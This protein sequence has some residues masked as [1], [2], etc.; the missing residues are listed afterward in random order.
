MVD[1]TGNA[2][3][4]IIAVQPNPLRIVA[5]INAGNAFGAGVVWDAEIY[6]YG[7]YRFLAGDLNAD[8]RT[9]LIAIQPSPLRMVAW[10]NNGDAFA[11]G[12]EWHTEIYD[13]SG[14][15]L[16]AGD[17]DGDNR[18]DI[19]AVQPNPLRIVT[20]KNNG[21]AFEGGVEWHTE[22][23]DYSGYRFFVGDVDGD[24][25]ADVIAIQSNPL[26]MVIW[27]NS[28]SG[29]AGGVEW[30]SEAYDYSGYLLF[31]GDIDADKRTDI[32]A[33]QPNPL[34]MVTWKNNGNGFEGGVEKHT[35]TYDYSGYR[36][37]IGD[38]DADGRADVIAIQSEP[39]RIV[40]WKNNGTDF[41]GGVQ[42]YPGAEGAVTGNEFAALFGIPSPD[43]ITIV[44]EF[45][46]ATPT[47]DPIYD[48]IPYGAPTDSLENGEP[49]NGDDDDGDHG[50]GG[51]DG[52]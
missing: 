37:L 26:R 49:D 48:E 6:N 42:W 39:M 25:R 8:G 38:I 50:D 9:D 36:F 31:G 19:V 45:F 23:Y 7:G 29:F 33:I 3:T 18:A 14:Y 21:N 1:L 5:W 10:K 11:G 27:K 2:L 17:I 34:R 30:H 41:N 16:F 52:N 22:T 12:V 15:I 47:A 40:T 35:E 32:I 4:D 46:N 51:D 13:Y 44:M 24:G 20:W 28:G 43:P